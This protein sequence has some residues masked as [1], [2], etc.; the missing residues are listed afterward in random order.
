MQNNCNEIE[1]LRAHPDLREPIPSDPKSRL[2]WVDIAKAM[3]IILIVLLHT[4]GLVSKTGGDPHWFSVFNA[5]M[6]PIRVPLFFVA[7]GLFA[8]ASVVGD[9]KRLLSRVLRLLWVFALWLLAFLLYFR[10]LVKRP[11]IPI[12]NRSIA[13]DF[14]GQLIAPDYIWFLWALALFF[15]AARVAMATAPRTILVLSAILSAAVTV[16]TIDPSIFPLPEVRSVRNSASYFFFFLAPV[17]Y[18]QIRTRIATVSVLRGLMIFIPIFILLMMVKTTMFG[19]VIAGIARTG[20]T[21][22]GVVVLLFF[23]R[24]IENLNLLSSLFKYLGKRTLQ[25]YVVHTFVVATLAVVAG[26]IGIWGGAVVD[27]AG[28]VILTA[29]GVLVSIL[30]AWGAQRIGLYWMFALPKWL[31]H[32]LS[33]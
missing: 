17:V 25:V 33:S 7:S 11:D 21:I 32:R 31:Q 3:S 18:P 23:A 26:S 6:S 9:V 19:A 30:F 8:R 4:T 2:E 1:G 10:F 28:V 24:A 12:T 29:T 15:I 13:E 14:L 20:A 16:V 5:I 27:Y 22:A